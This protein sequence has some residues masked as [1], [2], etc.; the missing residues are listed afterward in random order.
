MSGI[1][2]KDTKPELLLRKNL[3]KMGYR[4]RLHNRKL[5]GAPDLFLKKYNA[6]IFVNGCFWHGHDCHLFKWPKSRSEF[7]RDKIKG[8]IKRDNRNIELCMSRGLRVA[9]FWECSVKGRHRLPTEWVVSVVDEWLVD[10]IPKL[11]VSS[12]GVFYD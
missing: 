8:N 4:Y 5:P 2:N 1:K 10:T 9:V 11:S 12:L 3:F 7:W 6:V